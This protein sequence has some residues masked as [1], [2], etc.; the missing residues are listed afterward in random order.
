MLKKQSTKRADIN[1]VKNAT[2]GDKPLALRVAA[3]PAL[4]TEA[5][6]E[7]KSDI[8]AAG[9][10]ST[11]YVKTWFDIHDA[12]NWDAM[13]LAEHADRLPLTAEKITVVGAALKKAGWI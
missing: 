11:F 12:V 2:R 5:I 8:Y 4:L 3:D 1:I 13:N 7:Y 6:H 9:D 10:T